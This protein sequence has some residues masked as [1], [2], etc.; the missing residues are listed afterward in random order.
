MYFKLNK[1]ETKLVRAVLESNQW[2]GTETHD[3]NLLWSS[4]PFKSYI[5][6]NMNDYQKVNHFP[7]SE[8]MTR[9][10]KLCVNIVK[11]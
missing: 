4:Q 1:C 7:C 9:K 11:M 2:Q 10:D 5:Y 6:D 3:W 8:E